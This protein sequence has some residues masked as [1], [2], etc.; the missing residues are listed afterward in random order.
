MKPQRTWILIADGARARIVEN[1]GPGRGVH[2]LA[3]MTFASDHPA[4]HDIVDDR[5]GRTHASVGQA[6][7]AIDA[8]QDPHRELKRAFAR[9]LADTLARGA[10]QKA[11]D[12]VVL[13]APPVTLG[14][15]RACL[16]EL[17]KGRIAGELAHDLTK[18]PNDDVP[19]HLEGVIVL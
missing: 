11:F 14:D 4:T 18:I 7:S 15:L 12:R 16:D 1:D 6:R 5:E 8:H 13:V 19:R 10:K 3:G 9:S 17:V 2:A